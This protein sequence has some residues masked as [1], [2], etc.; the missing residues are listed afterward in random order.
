VNAL[1]QDEVWKLGGLDQCGCPKLEKLGTNKKQM[2]ARRVKMKLK[3][4]Y[5][6]Q[7]LLKRQEVKWRGKLL[8]KMLNKSKPK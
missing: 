4:S 5:E 2:N 1:H 3:G 8:K 7:V 6:P